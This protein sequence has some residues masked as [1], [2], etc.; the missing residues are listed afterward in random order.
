MHVY[1]GVVRC[2]PNPAEAATP[3]PLLIGLPHLVQIIITDKFAGFAFPARF[4]EASL[5]S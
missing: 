1:T 5:A 4:T 2:F 3:Y